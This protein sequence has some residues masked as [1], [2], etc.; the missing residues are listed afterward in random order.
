[1]D[2]GISPDEIVSKPASLATPSP[3]SADSRP[4]IRTEASPA[5]SALLALLCSA[6]PPSVKS[7]QGPVSLEIHVERTRF[8]AGEEVTG[9]LHV[10]RSSASKVSL[11]DIS[12]DLVGF[13]ETCGA[14]KSEVSR[15]AFASISLQLR[16]SEMDDQRA[17]TGSTA[18]AFR[19]RIPTNCAPEGEQTP[20]PP[21]YWCD[22]FGGIRYVVA[23]IMGLGGTARLIH[24]QEIE[25]VGPVVDILS[26]G[27][28]PGVSS[29]P[30]GPSQSAKREF[31]GRMPWAKA[32]GWVGMRATA[33]LTGGEKGAWTTGTRGLVEIA[34][35][36][37]SEVKLTTGRITLMRR[38]ATYRTE[39]A[40]HS[41]LRTDV[42]PATETNY[43]TGT[44][45]GKPGTFLAKTPVPWTERFAAPSFAEEAF[46]PGVA[47]GDSSRY[48]FDV[49][50]PPGARTTRGAL[51][52][53]QWIVEVAVGTSRQNELVVQIPVNIVDSLCVFSIG[54]VPR[55]VESRIRGAQPR[56]SK[57]AAPA[58]ESV[59]AT[60]RGDVGEPGNAQPCEDIVPDQS[61][62][63]RIPD[64]IEISSTAGTVGVNR[65]LTRE[66]LASKIDRLVHE[67]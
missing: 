45:V 28:Y 36:N 35:A 32:K 62:S 67:M 37:W 30:K 29:E 8:V 55:L 5:D 53:V 18:L 39:G 15:R 11:G 2:P 65:T 23:G 27:L 26:R 38:L 22:R 58:H 49:S 31:S 43:T 20:C 42:A 52:E 6:D 24:A 7:S 48:T 54:R 21:S 9:T 25:V 64:D 63:P 40:K 57:I 66:D 3:G 13:E 44:N 51:F 14:G 56:E 59:G 47:A 10:I 1:M 34:V 46:F 16:S 33:V 19:L 41:A 50:I 61:G 60:L 12:V 17:K 4:S